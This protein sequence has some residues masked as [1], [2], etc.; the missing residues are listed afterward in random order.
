MK[1]VGDEPWLGDKFSLDTV[2]YECLWLTVSPV[3]FIVS[4]AYNTPHSEHLASDFDCLTGVRYQREW[5]KLL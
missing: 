3:L 4:A 1:E 2:I 5:L